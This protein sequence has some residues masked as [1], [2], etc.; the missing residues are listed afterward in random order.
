MKPNIRPHPWLGGAHGSSGGTTA[1][2]WQGP[3]RC[4]AGA[5]CETENFADIEAKQVTSMTYLILQAPKSCFRGVP[6]GCQLAFC[7]ALGFN[8]R[9]LGE[10][11]LRSGCIV[12]DQAHNNNDGR[13]KS[14]ACFRTHVRLLF[15]PAMEA[16]LEPKAGKRGSRTRSP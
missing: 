4:A 11:R 12:C 3:R 8:F 7:L 1:A 9:Q 13:S 10:S 15:A 16:Q 6:W 14:R 2:V 5:R